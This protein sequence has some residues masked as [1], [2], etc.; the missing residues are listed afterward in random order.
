MYVSSVNS[1]SGVN[2]TTAGQI[3][4]S[5][6]LGKNDFLMLI[7]AQLKY[8]DPLSPV[9]N[10]DFIGQTAQFSMLEQII[11]LNDQMNVLTQLNDMNYTN[12]MLGKNVEWED[13]EGNLQQGV[14]EKIERLDGLL[15]LVSE[16]N[17]IAPSWVKS[18]L[19][20]EDVETETTQ[21]E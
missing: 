9:E 18:I 21:E 8:Q 3:V 15:W 13:E 14:I 7:T 16:G 6:D 19:N 5:S 10:F 2:Q 17:Y 11:N 12:G 1:T 4:S 20:V